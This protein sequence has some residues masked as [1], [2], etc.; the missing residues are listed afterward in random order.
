MRTITRRTPFASTIAVPE[1]RAVIEK[2]AP[3]VLESPLA[4]AVPQAPTATLIGLVLGADDP[5][6]EQIMSELARVED[7]TVRPDPGTPVVPSAS[8]E[9]SDITRGSAP[10]TQVDSVAPGA[11]E[12]MFDG[13]MHGNPFLDVELRVEFTR[14]DETISVG[15]F[16]DGDGTYRVRF[17]PPVRGEWA[18]STRSNARSLDGV[19]GTASAGPADAHGPVRID[20]Q[21]FVYD[22]GAPYTPIGTTAYVWTLQDEELQEK[23]IASLATSPFTKIRMGLF[24]KDYVYNRNEPERYPFARTGTGWD[25]ERFDVVYFRNLEERIA[26]LAELGIEADLI[27]FHP[28]D[29]WG[30]S[31]MSAT[32][33][34]RYVTYVVRRLAGFRNVWWS[35]ANEYD[36][37]TS[38]TDDDWDRIGETVASEDHVGHPRSIH[39]WVDLYD[40]SKSWVTHASIQGGGSSMAERVAKWRVTWNKPIVIDE[41]GY[42][43]DLDQGWGNLTG[44]EVVRRFWEGT[45]AGGYLTHGET[46]YADDEVVFWAKGGTLRGESLP[47]LAFLRTIVEASP[48]GAIAPLPGDWDARWA[49]VA[50]QYILISFGGA[51]PAFRHVPIPDGMTARIE[52]ID[53]WH[54]TIDEVPGTHTGTVRVA[55]PARPH[56][57]IRLT[58]V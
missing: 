38:K 39:N 45:V 2:I 55:L 41:F 14:G 43:G 36:L 12:L 51:R 32:V 15:G 31:S 57:L 25:T 27:L 1:G 8:Y 22:D 35:L 6:I 44:E 24:P 29:R 30:F 21:R 58:A 34:D 26:Q 46:F 5:R 40:F 9:G 56:V 28:Y 23:T 18:F 11:I 37:L 49:G 48:T 20:G 54:M 16:Y 50:G 42:E 52:I 4:T 10:V 3:V 47:R 17:L 33:D 53:A 7:V 19:E 13:P